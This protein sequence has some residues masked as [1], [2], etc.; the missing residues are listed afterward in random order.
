MRLENIATRQVCNKRARATIKMRR[1][2][3]ER[4]LMGG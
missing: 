1:E 4:E 3:I 2:Y